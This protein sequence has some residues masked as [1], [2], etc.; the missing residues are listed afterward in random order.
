MTI[1]PPVHFP[2]FFKKIVFT[3]YCKKVT[4]DDGAKLQ[5]VWYINAY[6]LC[7]ATAGSATGNR[8]HVT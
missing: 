7:P 5:T 6:S 3:V 8:T 1:L 4:V 2:V